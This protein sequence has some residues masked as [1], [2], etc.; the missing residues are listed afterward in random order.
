MKRLAPTL[1][2]VL[3][4]AGSVWAAPPTPLTRLSDIH[5]LTN[6]E[7]SKELPVAFEATVTYY[8]GY[9]TTLVVQDGSAGIYV[10]APKDAK[11]VPG[12][13]VLIKGTTR[14]SFN[15]YIEPS[16]ITL[17]RHGPQLKPLPSNFDQMIRAQTDCQLVA[18][19]G[20]VHAA[21]MALTSH[22]P[23]IFLQLLTD[24]GYFVVTVDSSDA[25]VLDGLLDAEVLV[26]GVASE[27]FDS[28]MQVTGIRI[29]VQTPAGIQ[30]LKR[31]A[32]SPWTL[33][34]TPMERVL[35]VYH[36]TDSTPRVRV[37]GTI[38]YYAPGSA[39]VLQD[40]AKSIWIATQTNIP[41]R[42]GD[43]ADATGFPD[44]HNGFLSLEHG[45]IRD[46]LKQA[47][48]TPLPATWQTLS[49]AGVS[50]SG[51]HFDLVSI[52]GQVVTQVLA[53]TQ[54]EYVLSA[55]GK[56]FS[57][58]LRRGGDEPGENRL[59]D[60]PQIP[61]GS[62]V[63]VTGICI[64]DSSNPYIPQV[65]FSILLRSSDDIEIVK[66][67]PWLNIRNLILIAGLLL[68]AF[69]MASTWGW[70]AERKV[71]CQTAAMSARTE[72]EAELERRRSRI[73]EHI[74]GPRLL[75][76]VLEEIVEMVT[77]S[78]RGVPCWCETADGER[79]GNCPG[80]QQNL[81]IEQ[82]AIPSR[83]GSS[84]GSIYAG[85]NAGIPAS[86]VEIESLQ[87]GARLAT[88]AI[89]TRRLYSDLRRRS[90]FDL[91]TDIP[92][93]FAMERYIRVQIEE[94]KKYG[95]ILGLIYIDLDKFKPINDTYGHHV[96]DLFLQAVARRMSRQLLGSDMLA[97][98]GGDEFAA[99]VTL[100][101]GVS[102]LK[103]IVARLDQ[104]F[105]RPFVIEEYAIQ[106][107]A[108]IGYALYPQD[109]VTPDE[110]LNAADT[111]MY[112]VKNAR[113]LR[114]LPSSATEI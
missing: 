14:P 49:P 1:A 79:L 62:R 107:A 2:L 52:E 8:R 92:N 55:D 113:K 68:V 104:C 74:N 51:H 112:V 83:S 95:S 57:A 47:P 72:S 109:G 10:Y 73:L 25:S 31:A 48:I 18:V 110:L 63:R 103:T 85:F 19:R 82:A 67:P 97:R 100:P 101:H 93:R 61:L 6:A 44:T 99:L 60:G 35:A 53:V 102:D 105:L 77:L 91:L 111:A 28:K 24:G 78:L 33:P 20:V 23:S 7:A 56:V 4:W 27:E 45:E 88:L 66:N 87:S 21:D 94:A 36:M 80:E 90:E 30:V 70:V 5:R 65:P 9:E 17:L 42:I 22:V 69:A 108:S 13:R 76:E 38:T 41:L 81:R 39:V 11:L 46:S 114:N 3:L 29:H 106:G 15:P 98:L 96:G 50:S 54:D 58:F 64:R 43:A 34:V 71:R 59:P 40:G 84:L 32:G 75:A 12:D 16:S 86:G 37:H 26:T 89:E